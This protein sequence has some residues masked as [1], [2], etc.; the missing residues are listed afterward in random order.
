MIVTY[1]LTRKQIRVYWL[2]VNGVKVDQ[3][4]YQRNQY[5]R[6]SAE[7]CIAKRQAEGYAYVDN[8]GRPAKQAEVA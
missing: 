2:D 7:R 3:R 1:E 6:V 5:G 4:L 8:A